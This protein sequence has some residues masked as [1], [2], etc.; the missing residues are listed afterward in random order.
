MSNFDNLIDKL[1]EDLEPVKPMATPLQRAIM[2]FFGGLFSV[3]LVGAFLGF[4]M[5][6]DEKVLEPMFLTELSLLFLLSASAA[7]ASAWLSLP[8]GAEKSKIIIVPYLTVAAAAMIVLS[9]IFQHGFELKNFSFHHCMMDAMMMGAVPV[10]L[11]I[12]MMRQGATTRPVLS[13]LTNMI[14]AGGIGYIGLRIT[15][16]SDAI[17]HMCA[18]HIMP[19]VLGG[20]VLGLIA[21]KLYH[22]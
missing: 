10:F 3:I 22:W 9:E 7:Y 11:M 12:W 5:D 14:A 13:A 18:Y 2:W 20:L 17:G 15:C 21:R 8:D 19:F 6:L 4:R 1:G 16:G